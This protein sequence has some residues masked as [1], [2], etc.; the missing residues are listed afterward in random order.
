MGAYIYRMTAKKVK[1]SNGEQANVAV[2]AY[3]PY[4]REKEDR[5]MHFR[6][7]ATASDLMARRGNL[8]AYFV[9]GDDNGNPRPDDQRVFRNLQR[10]GSFSDCWGGVE[11]VMPLAEGV[12]R[13]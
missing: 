7:G 4:G 10:R 1:L 13:V 6:S 8:C 12:T 3:K 5:A 9:M 2:Y 11:D